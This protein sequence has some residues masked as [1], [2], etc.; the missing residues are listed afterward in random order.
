MLHQ[1]NGIV[2]TGNP[3]FYI[4]D[5]LIPSRIFPHHNTFHNSYALPHRR[6]QHRGPQH[7]T[8]HK[9]QQ[10]AGELLFSLSCLNY[11][12]LSVGFPHA[13]NRR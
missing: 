12:L 5:K 8:I 6:R 9:E 10:L 11:P 7:L 2:G 4:P 13:P 1:L 3:V